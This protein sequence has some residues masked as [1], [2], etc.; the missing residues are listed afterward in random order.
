[1]ISYKELQDCDCGIKQ[2]MHTQIRNIAVKSIKDSPNLPEHLKSLAVEV[3][4]KQINLIP[5]YLGTMELCW[6][7]T[8]AKCEETDDS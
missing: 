8:I 3:V 6:R 2:N 5:V 1:M 7:R 4:T